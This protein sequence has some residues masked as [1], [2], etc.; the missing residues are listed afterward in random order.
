M[1]TFDIQVQQV[2]TQRFGKCL[3]EL[4]GN[5][6]I[7]VNKDANVDMATRSVLFAAAGTAGQRCTTTRRLFVHEAVYDTVLAKL[8][9]GFQKLRI[10]DPLDDKVVIGP[11]HTKAAVDMYQRCLATIRSRGGK[12][13]SG[14]RVIAGEGNFVEPTIVTGKVAIS[15]SDR[16]TK[17]DAFRAGARRSGGPHGDVCAD[18]VC[19]QDPRPGRGYRVE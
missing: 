9:S 18:F 6:A 19:R 3:L 12:I 1:T 14:G 15:P 8:V 17:S 13:E 16:W 10:G 2:V 5:N 7:I 11:L 4:G